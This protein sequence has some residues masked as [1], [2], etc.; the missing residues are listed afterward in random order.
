MIMI[1]VGRSSA[2]VTNNEC[3]NTGYH[4]EPD[5]VS[6]SCRIA[7]GLRSLPEGSRR[8]TTFCARQLTFSADLISLLQEYASGIPGFSSR[9]GENYA[10]GH[11]EATGGII[12]KV[13]QHLMTRTALSEAGRVRAAVGANWNRRLRRAKTPFDQ[14]Q[15][16]G[17]DQGDQRLFHCRS[18]EV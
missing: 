10:R 18:L 7:S 3:A 15:A 16:L 2:L 1:I 17:P 12:P 11:K 9:V 4:P 5:K 6:F 8:E 13:G 14:L